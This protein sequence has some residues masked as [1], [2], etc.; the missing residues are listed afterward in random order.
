MLNSFKPYKLPLLL[1]VLILICSLWQLGA[2][3]VIESSEARYAEI[4]REMLLDNNLIIPQYLGI[5][6]FDKPLMTYWITAA[7]YTL[8]GVNPFGARFFLQ[9]ALI[10]Q[11]LLVYKITLSLFK[12]K[13]TAL[14][15]L[16]CYASLPLVLMSVRNLTT[17]AYLN[18][19][20]LSA[21]YFYVLFRQKQQVWALYT[22]FF[23]LGLAIFTKGPFA[24]ILPLL[25]IY[26]IN[27]LLV[28]EHR[29][30]TTIHVIPGAI[31]MLAL[32]SWWF[33]YLMSTSSE[34]YDFFIGEQLINRV[35]HAEKLNRSQPFW[36]YF[37][38]LPAF[39]IPVLGLIINWLANLKNS[40]RLV[41]IL[42]IFT[43]A[44]PLLVFSSA[45]SKLVLYILPI[46]P[47]VAICAAYR[48]TEVSGRA[49]RTILTASTIFYGI[50]ILALFTVSLGFIGAFAVTPTLQLMIFL[51]ILTAFWG[52][53]MLTKAGLK[54]K[55]L[56]QLLVLPLFVI[57]LSTNIMQQK[58]VEI[59]GTGPIAAFIQ[60][61]MP[62]ANVLV[63]N[64]VLNSM[65]FNLEK[66][67]YSLKFNH[68]SLER[69]TRFQPDDS[70]KNNLID[71]RDITAQPYLRTLLAEPSVLLRY[72]K[73]EI[74]DELGWIIQNFP[75]QKDFDKFTLYYK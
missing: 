52:Y 16:I 26:P 50:V 53:S 10:V 64:R 48:L 43:I 27:R 11:L 44:I 35:A 9:I 62:D 30:N 69:N 55:F 68:Y 74:P 46:T 73:D 4:P 19:F 71:V 36:Y 72:K 23:A 67:L 47:F 70:W 75:H 22:F 1:V 57:P 21:I 28:P 20:V 38:L 37:A 12:D 65:S 58:E 2:W 8:W 63:W 40:N 17:D 42:G 45:S 7:G 54:H 56:L 32:G 14:Y 13:K 31:L 41:N 49:M 5:M 39:I 15:A 25:A 33:F 66:P 51:V 61:Q 6:H 24:L 59:N 60:Q 34:F 18:T 3:G 29:K